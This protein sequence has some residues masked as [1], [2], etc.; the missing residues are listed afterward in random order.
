MW[1]YREPPRC[2]LPS[3][4]GPSSPQPGGWHPLTARAL[5]PGQLVAG[6]GGPGER[7]PVAVRAAGRA[8]G[9]DAD[10]D[11]AGPRQ[12]HLRAAGQHPPR[13]PPHP[14]ATSPTAA[15]L[16]SPPQAQLAACAKA[17]ESSEELLEAANQALGTANHHDFAQ[18]G[19][20]RCGGCPRPAAPHAGG[21]LTPLAGQSASPRGC[22][23]PGRAPSFSLCWALGQRWAGCARCGAAW[24]HGDPRQGHPRAAWCPL[25]PETEG[26]GGR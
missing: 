17:L 6:A 4:W 21:V 14:R 11:Q 25:S 20:H 18:V 24:E 3:P 2:A 9:P 26:H 12:P 10:E 23:H 8:E 7:V 5:W 19:P 15:P 16:P 1:R 13:V 22:A